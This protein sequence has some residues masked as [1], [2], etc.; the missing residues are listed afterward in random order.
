V[1]NSPPRRVTPRNLAS[2][3][4]EVEVADTFDAIDAPAAAGSDVLP[5]GTVI[6]QR[7]EITRL[8]GKGGMGSV[9]VA[10]D[11]ELGREVA[12]KLHRAHGGGERLKRE[13]IAMARLAHQNVVAVFEVGE[14][15]GQQFVVMEYVPGSTLRAWG[16]KQVRPWR[17]VIAMMIAAGEGLAAAHD[18]GLVHRDFKP[19]N[20]LVGADGRPRVGDFGLARDTDSVDEVPVERT[21]Q[22]QK[23]GTMTQAGAMVGT[24]VYMPPEQ[25]AGEVVDA[26]VDQFAFSVTTWE[27]LWGK[28]P[29]SGS[30]IEELERAI[31]EGPKLPPAPSDA[32][33][34]LRVALAR[35]LAAKPDERYPDMHALLAALRAASH[36]RRRWLIEAAAAFA[37]V[38]VVVAAFALRERDTTPS[39]RVLRMS[40]LTRGATLELDPAI[41]PDGQR[42]VYTSGQLGHMQLYVRSLAGGPTTAL[43]TELPGD[44]R[45]PQWS[46]D[47]SQI[48]FQS[49]VDSESEIDIVPSNGGPTRRFIAPAGKTATMPAWSPDGVWLA[50]ILAGEHTSPPWEL[51]VARVDGST[52]RSLLSLDT[53]ESL[54]TPSWSPDS[55]HIA[56]S[57]GN[58]AF[59]LHGNIAPASIWTIDAAG[60]APVQ[61]TSGSSLNHGPVWAPDGRSLLFVSDRDGT[62]DI[63]QVAVD[64]AGAP[65]GQPLRLTVGLNAHT[66][67]VGDKRL[68]CSVFTYRTNLWSVPMPIEDAERTLADA[69]PITTGNQIIESVDPSPDNRWL[70]FDSN[71]RGKQN[72]YVMPSIGGDPV[73]VTTGLANDFAPSWSPDA[74]RIAF[75]SFRTGTR[76]LFVTDRDGS[77][78]TELTSGS[79][80]N[81]SPQWSPD[82]RA[83]A[84]YSDRSGDVGVYTVP[85]RGGTPRRLANG[86]RP[87][88]NPD[89]QSLTFETPS[90]LWKIAV[91][92]GTPIQLL[93]DE[94]IVNHR[95][96]PD[97]RTIYLRKQE[98]GGIDG[99]WAL[100]ASGGQPRRVLRLA[101]PTRHPDRR[102]FAVDDHRFLLLLTEHDA[103][104]WLLELDREP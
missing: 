15:D 97:G 13:A 75:H 64:D 86:T 73:A 29:F 38:A 69:Q 25:I 4:A 82:G 88:W 100:P 84:F 60:G 51:V 56:F 37:V 80:N 55:K 33:P 11:L 42:L 103:D 68:I 59:W 16:V 92:G 39:V 85:A 54:S 8:L 47:G 36:R 70:A 65:V 6:D 7:F 71:L 57:R 23:L 3:P 40:Q 24:P 89:S 63:Y 2:T 102:E 62:R 12:I 94:H 19:E 91:G 87:R 58:A 104:L 90:G 5:A 72:L 101:D 20:V 1:S 35:G 95:W 93:A 45:S 52:P 83:I 30:T 41:S 99:I 43:A 78:I 53:D 32:P 9:Y 27:M 28:R 26:R 50:Y 21:S 79:A 61:V 14:L 67:A 96:S 81:W 18:A 10:R 49:G 34:A 44:H 98:L 66:I 22:S 46:H 31:A 17:D 48:A 77:D 76:N 74:R